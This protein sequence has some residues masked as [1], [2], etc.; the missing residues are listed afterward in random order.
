MNEINITDNGGRRKNSDRRQFSYTCHIPE[1]RS[2]IDRRAGE[3][4]RKDNR[5]SE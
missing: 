1:R 3:D 2:G 5:Y 4:R